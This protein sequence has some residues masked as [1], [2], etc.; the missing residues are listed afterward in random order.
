MK[1]TLLPGVSKML[2][3][4][5]ILLATALLSASCAHAAL[6]SWHEYSSREEA[7]WVGYFQDTQRYWQIVLGRTLIEVDYLN[8]LIHVSATDATPEEAADQVRQGARAIV[9]GTELWRMLDKKPDTVREELSAVE[10]R[11][12]D[13]FPARNQ[14]RAE[15]TL[16]FRR[17]HLMQRAEKY[18]NT[19]R[20]TCETKGL[21]INLIMAVIE[22]ES[23]FNPKAFSSKGAI[24]LMQL[25]PETGGRHA[26]EL[27]GHENRTPTRGDLEDP[28]LNIQLGCTY[29]AY[30]INQEFAYVENVDTRRML[31]LLAYNWGLSNVH[32]RL[33]PPSEL[34]PSR[35]HY[36]LASIPQ[37]T[38]GY[39]RRI[40]KRREYYQALL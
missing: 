22:T 37:E 32:R 33:N 13:I 15:L 29:L 21:P 26:M 30:L 23:M 27:R 19:V 4:R 8:G 31:G 18:V 5:P 28:H 9:G 17:D 10:T 1:W 3:C 35:L 6:T 36:Q 39:L 40:L 24:G 12:P 2:R 38:R 14:H 20:E 34:S 11:E 25:V 16:Y 7:Q